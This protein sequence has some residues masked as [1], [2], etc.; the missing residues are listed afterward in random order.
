VGKKRKKGEGENT[1]AEKREHSKRS[2]ASKIMANLIEKSQGKKKK[3]NSTTKNKAAKH[4]RR[5]TTS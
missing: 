2:K 4:R 3:T 1:K 5:R